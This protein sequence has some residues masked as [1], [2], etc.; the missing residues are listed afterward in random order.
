MSRWR[1]VDD[2][3]P[4]PG[5]EVLT[6]SGVAK[7]YPTPQGWRWLYG[8]PGE[9]QREGPAPTGWVP[10]PRHELV[11]GTPIAEPSFGLT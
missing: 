2:Q 6:P 1:D 10:L 7:R 5:L 11:A 8:S 4:R 3:H 9:D